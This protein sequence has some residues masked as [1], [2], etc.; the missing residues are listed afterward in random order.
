MVSMASIVKEKLEFR[1]GGTAC[2]GYLYRKPSESPKPC[3]IMGAGFG[4][5]QDTPSMT[6]VATALAEAGYHAF[7]F[8]YRHLGESEGE[9][10]QLVSVPG[11]Q[12][13]FL[14]AIR[15]IK[16]H[17][18]VDK[19]RLGLWGSSLGGGHVISVAAKTK[20]IVAVIAQIPF[21]G[22]PK[23]SGRSLWQTLKLLHIIRKDW[24][25]GQK[26]LS[27]LYIPAVG[28]KG[29]LAVMAGDEAAKTI[30]GMQS[31]TWRNEVAPRGIVEMIKYKPSYTA[32]QIE[33][34]VLVCYGEY[35]RETQGPQ[36]EELI[37]SIPHAEVKAYPVTHFEFYEPGIREQIIADQIDF[38]RRSF[39]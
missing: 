8:D 3:V 26:G 19:T 1:S 12:E 38:L 7:T 24:K 2:V 5:T 37:R 17:P 13:D 31:K 25:R 16:E 23:K 18:E 20:G 33:A 34:A 6:A 11:Q 15:F 4:G 22:F 29:E 27:P 39:S 9:P 35:D 14:S 28:S 32:N 21:N 30:A 36:T 10:R